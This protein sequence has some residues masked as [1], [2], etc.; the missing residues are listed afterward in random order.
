MAGK[1]EVLDTGQICKCTKKLNS[2]L[3]I[4]AKQV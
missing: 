1:V 4:S 3:E 2:S